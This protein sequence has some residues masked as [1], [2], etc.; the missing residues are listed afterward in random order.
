MNVLLINPRLKFMSDVGQ[1]PWLPLG[2]MCLSSY[3]KKNGIATKILDLNFT[4]L[5]PEKTLDFDIVGI[6]AVTL[7][8][9][10]AIAI[11]KEIKAINNNSKIIF[12][13]PHFLS[14]TE[15]DLNY[16]DA[17]VLSEGEITL[18]DICRGVPFNELDGIAFKTTS[19][20]VHKD[21]TSF[22]EDIDEIPYPD[23][24]GVSVYDYGDS[25]LEE[26]SCGNMNSVCIQTARGCP[27]N[28]SFCASPILWQRKVR[29]Y[30]LDYVIGHIKHVINKYGI[31][32]FRIMD[33]TIGINKKRVYD[34][35]DR[36]EQEGL[37]LKLNCY[38]KAPEADLDLFKR[39]VSVGFT[40][41]SIGIESGNQRVLD[42][43]DKDITLEDSRTAVRLA[44][45]AGLF[46]EGLY[47]LGHMGETAET[48]KD[49]Y[50]FSR[51]LN[52]TKSIFF[53]ATPF[54][55]TRFYKEYKQHGTLI[56]DNFD[57]YTS[58]MPVFIPKGLSKDSLKDCM[59]TCADNK[60]IFCG[61]D[62]DGV[63]QD[64]FILSKYF[65]SNRSGFFVEAGASD[66]L[67]LSVCKVLESLGWQGVNIEADPVTFER[68]KKNR[69]TSFNIN[70]A[71]SNHKGVL[72]FQIYEEEEYVLYNHAI[73]SI[74]EHL[75][76]T[77]SA[78]GKME[79]PKKPFER[80]HIK[81]VP[82]DTYLN[83]VECL[84][85][86]VDFMVLD[87]ECH[88]LAVIEGMRGCK[89][90]PEILLV[91][92]LHVGLDAIALSLSQL[93]YR[94]DWLGSQD[95]VFVRGPLCACL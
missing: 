44:K 11:S 80:T 26:T 19:G 29:Y 89:N 56:S 25:I 5:E 13:G 66:G 74:T 58:W 86:K 79:L 67:L 23:Y 71:L 47:M 51:E 61:Q 70:I 53:Y 18:L 42:I 77:I 50:T 65:A 84:D 95:A 4:V 85:K 40:W 20:V 8:Y 69:P 34:F 41:V 24:G 21:K 3:L 90:I 62:V 28:C 15:N 92:H 87:V 55:G 22:I 30:S 32:N 31:T 10:A 12:G 76:D 54:P 9:N 60:L 81:S 27:Y 52:A 7:Q 78:V 49:T 36:L 6:S 82:C 2:L 64:E 17:C 83:V 35:C 48:L 94:L 91:E 43:I 33:E 93:G 39:M 37:K 75:S 88:E 59:S 14:Y 1:R 57:E 68:L 72:D 38:F 46:V 45:Q 63:P 73:S 16:C